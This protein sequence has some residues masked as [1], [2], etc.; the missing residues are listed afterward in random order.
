MG[1]TIANVSKDSTAPTAEKCY[2][3]ATPSTKATSFNVE[4]SG[5]KDSESGVKSVQ[6]AAYPSSDPGLLKWISGT[7]LGGGSWGAIVDIADFKNSY[8]QYTIEVFGTDNAGNTA[9]MG[10]TIAT[11]EKDT[12]PPIAQ[13]VYNS[14]SPTTNQKYNVEASGVVDPAGVK[15]VEFITYPASRPTMQR[16]DAGTYLGNNTWGA[17][18]DVANYEYTSGIYITEVFATDNLGNRGRI[19]VTQTDV[20]YEG[21]AILGSPGATQ[22]QMVN[23]Y[24]SKRA[25]FPAIY[26]MTLEQFVSIYYEEAQ[27]EGIK[28]EVAFAQ[29]CKETGYLDYGG[30]VI[31]TQFNFAGIKTAD[32]S[33]FQTFSNPREGVRAQV[34]HLKCYSSTINKNQLK[35]PCVDPRWDAAVS[36]GYQG[37]V[38]SVQALG[39]RWAEDVN[40]GTDLVRM[41]NEIL[42]CSKT[43]QSS[44]FAILPEA[45]PSIE[46]EATPSIEPEATPS[47]EPEATPSIEPEVMP[48]VEPGMD[49]MAKADVVDKQKMMNL[50]QSYANTMQEDEAYDADGM[51]VAYDIIIE[52]FVDM[53]YAEAVREGVDPMVA[54]AQGMLETDFLRSNIMEYNLGGFENKAFS[55]L[56]TGIRAQVQH[57]KCLASVEA[58]VGDIVDPLWSEELRGRASTVEALQDVWSGDQGY[59]NRILQLVNEMN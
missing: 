21:Y 8:G 48:G 16:F 17:T 18:V 13:K 1:V 52:E 40:Y 38:T 32:G 44:L 22:Q 5:V 37:T 15:S 31:N 54:F 27:A 7:D 33:G 24:K 14:G 50:F 46:P 39:G 30:S 20:K 41:I 35:Y 29:M 4:T 57:L 2:N 19:G 53:Y 51:P 36:A 11:V 28:P 42:S 56:Q 12:T 34:Q 59:A 26:G 9:R 55:D 47:I 49:I 6:F 58:C 10:V 25:S 45:T 43:A 23:F 3:N